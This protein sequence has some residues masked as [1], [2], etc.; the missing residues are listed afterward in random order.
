[1]QIADMQGRLKQTLPFW[2]EVLCALP[3]ILEC[4][5]HVYRL[6]LKFI[7]PPHIQR[8]HQSSET[9]Q[10]FVD[11]ALSSLITNHCLIKVDLQPHVCSPIS[12]V[13]NSM[14]RLWLVLNL[15]YV[16]QFFHVL[17]FKYEDLRVAALMFEKNEFLFKFDLK[18][19]YHHVDIHPECYK[20]LVFSRREF[21]MSLQSY[22]LGYLVPGT[23]SLSCYGHSF[24]CGG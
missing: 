14:E 18:S 6:T 15:R 23:Y 20:F 17:T 22:L 21:S 7:P 1:V 8:N 4:I 16:N 9:H 2:R 11:D 10:S 3:Q 12:V 5:G 24:V 13:S 19:G